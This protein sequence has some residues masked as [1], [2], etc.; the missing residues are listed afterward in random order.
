M[1]T[2]ETLGAWTVLKLLPALMMITSV[3]AQ[4]PTSLRQQTASLSLDLRGPPL[5]L[6]GL[7]LGVY[8]PLLGLAVGCWSLC[9]RA[10]RIV[11]CALAWLA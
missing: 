7:G 2:I 1:H 5:G 4:N 9:V 10:G 11:V 3:T 8:H 6:Q